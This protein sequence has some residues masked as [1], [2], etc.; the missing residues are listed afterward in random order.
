MDKTSNE[1]LNTSDLIKSSA[2]A[3]VIIVTAYFLN[4]GI[5]VM[6]ARWL[7][8]EIYGDYAAGINA[9]RITA[10]V[11]LLGMDYAIIRFIPEYISVADW[12][13]ASGYLRHSFGLLMRIGLSTFFIGLALGFVLY[14]FGVGGILAFEKSHP[15]FLF[16]WA[17]PL[18]A[19]NTY[20]GKL[21]RG[22]QHIYLSLVTLNI[23]Q[24]I[25]LFLM[26]AVFM[27]IGHQV[28]VYEAMFS[29]VISTVMVLLWQSIAIY[30]SLPPQVMQ[31]KP[32]YESKWM[33]VA[34][35]LF[36]SGFLMANFNSIVV[37]LSEIFDPTEKNTGI[38]F[39]I[40][41][42]CNSLWLIAAALLTVMGPLISPAAKQNDKAKLQLLTNVSIS[43][44]FSGGLLLLF[45]MILFGKNILQHFGASFVTGYPALVTL[46]AVF[47]FA[48]MNGVSV[49]LLQYSGHQNILIKISIICTILL[50]ILSGILSYFYGLMGSV[51]AACIVQVLLSLS[52]SFWVRK[53]LGVKPFIWV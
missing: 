40:F 48:L 2:M 13:A 6:L 18:V 5:N 35:Q 14:I 43:V 20:F 31:S 27:L 19:L 4:Y 42:I 50:I 25:T 36:V 7:G 46:T 37:I 47:A 11:M 53:K 23:A 39:A 16:L 41:T 22:T 15:F 34:I 10:V 52:A 30:N 28:N 3:L 29:F 21:L 9:L 44:M 26:L 49:S 32:R 17:I 33:S 38:L 45:V 12:S 51:I 8:G 24:P 1:T